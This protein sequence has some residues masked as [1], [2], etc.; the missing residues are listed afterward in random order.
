MNTARH[1]LTDYAP[2]LRQPNVY[3]VAPG[4][5]ACALSTGFQG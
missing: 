3:N 5:A 2:F 4:T 1:T